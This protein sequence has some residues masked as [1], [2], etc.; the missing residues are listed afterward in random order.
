MSEPIEVKAWWKSTSTWV[1]V[2]TI[3][4][5]IYESGLIPADSPG[6]KILGVVVA[7]LVALGLI[8]KRGLIENT[9]IK[10]NALLA[11]QPKD[12]PSPPAG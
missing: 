5:V 11:A 7:A 2:A 3:V 9:T 1:A 8:A 4:A 12:P 6:Y 10:A